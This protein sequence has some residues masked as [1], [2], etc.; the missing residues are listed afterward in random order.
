[1]FSDKKFD[2]ASTATQNFD[3]TRFVFLSNKKHF[4]YPIVLAKQISIEWITLAKTFVSL[5]FQ[6][7]SAP[8]SK[9]Y[10]I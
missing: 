9:K 4:Y 6:V 1:M 7:T 2:N 8:F 5:A 10:F 3:C